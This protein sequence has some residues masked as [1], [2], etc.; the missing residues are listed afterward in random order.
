MVLTEVDD[1]IRVAGTMEFGAK[2]N[3][4]N[5]VRVDALRKGARLYL[6]DWPADTAA[7]LKEWAGSRPMTMDGLPIIGALDKAPNVFVGGGHGML[8]LT[9]GGGTAKILADMLA[10]RRTRLSDKHLQML[11]PNR[12]SRV[13]ASIVKKRR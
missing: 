7:E 5:P 2:D 13:L 9:M 10:G 3:S 12:F 4:L 11:S 1:F 6:R 8:G